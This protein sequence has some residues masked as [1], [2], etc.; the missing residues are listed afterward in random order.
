[1]DVTSSDPAAGTAGREGLGKTYD[2]FISYAHA[3]DE[4]FSAALQRGL[5]HLAKP[6]NRRRAMEVFRDETS[7]SA[8]SGLEPSIWRALDASSWLVLLASPEAARSDWVSE[9]ITHWVSTKGA[10]HLLVVVTEGTWAWDKSSGDLSAA[11]TAAG[12][13]LRGVFTTEPKYVDMTWA[14]HDAD[15]TLRNANFRDQVATLAAAIREVSK[16]DIEGEDVKQQRRTRRIVRAV[17]AALTMLVLVASSLAIWANAERL[18]AV[19]NLKVALS[20]QLISNSELL[21]DTNPVLSKL[22]S[23]AAWRLNP[24]ASEARYAIL[25]AA[26][27]TGLAVLNGSGGSVTSVAFSPDG[28]ILAGG[29]SDGT[30]GLWDAATRQQVGSILA[31]RVSPVESV[32]FSPD[33]RVLASAIGGTA[34]AGTVRLWDVATRQQIGSP[35]IG[36][37]GGVTSVAFSPD[38]RI[39]ASGTGDGTVRL[40]DVATGQQIGS[41]LAAGSGG[42]GSVAFSPD[43]KILASGST[44]GNNEGTVQLWD[45]ATRQQIGSPLPDGSG[46]VRS[47]A[48]SPDGRILASGGTLGDNEGT[49]RLWNIATHQQIGSPLNGSGGTVYSV[50]FSPDG[51]TLA[52]AT[53]VTGL[54][55]LGVATVRLWDVG[56]QQQLGDPLTGLAGPVYSVAFSPDGK[57]LASGNG[58]GTMRLWDV[59]TSRQQIGSPLA[60]PVGP[61]NSVAFSPDGK[62]LASGNTDGTERLWD[63]AT[64]QPIGSPLAGPLPGL[65]GQPS[66]DAVRVTGSGLV[67]SVTFSPDGGTLASAGGTVQLRDLASGRII[68]NLGTGSGD[69]ESVAFSPDGKILAD[70][71]HDGTVW[72]WDVATQRQIGSPLASSPY[73]V[74]SVAFSP[75]GKILAGGNGDGTVWLWDVATHQQIGSPLASSLEGFASVAF[76]PDGK[77]LA[78]GNGDGTVRLWDVATH[79]Q[80]GTLSGSAGAVNSVAFSP[81]GETLASGNGDG[82]VV[83][84]DVATHQQIGSPLAG[85]AGAVESVAFSPDGKILASGNADGTVRLW[86]ISYLTETVPDLCVSAGRSLTQTEWTQYVQGLAYQEVCP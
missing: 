52:S 29:N 55:A 50:A 33:G 37:S 25:S 22:L 5:Q 82:T 35:L 36:G 59:A 7:L 58:D 40:W 4:G 67:T 57:A 42:V 8:S 86:D 80:I 45:V 84:W 48:F 6:W 10:D 2:A 68:G 81:D 47:V 41:P 61:V 13:A 85:P 15:L 24:S 53:G 79:Q 66:G 27:L 63:P 60:G 1:M 30:V 21:G 56:S 78:S 54:S 83:L 31:S 34:G 65:L 14:R 76:S 28:K 74:E 44:L 64:G 39:L 70:G 23:I 32:A 62:T 73:G 18:Q 49:V 26:A 77:I 9:E 38:G 46:D 75:D 3:G 69:A 11:S 12:R 17:I 51:K 71:N 72:L 20:G 19:H 16:E 43:G